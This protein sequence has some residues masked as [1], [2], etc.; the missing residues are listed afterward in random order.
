MNRNKTLV[1]HTEKRNIVS[2]SQNH[3]YNHNKQESS[4]TIAKLPEISRQKQK[5]RPVLSKNL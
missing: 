1:P 4:S 5:I 3:S 2:R